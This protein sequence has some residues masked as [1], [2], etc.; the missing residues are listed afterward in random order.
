MRKPKVQIEN[1]FAS[2]AGLKS[3]IVTGLGFALYC[4]SGISHR[5]LSFCIYGFTLEPLDAYSLSHKEDFPKNK[6]IIRLFKNNLSLLQLK[7]LKLQFFRYH[8]FRLFNK[9]KYYYGIQA[10]MSV[11]CV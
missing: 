5:D 7:K 2:L 1:L 10:D 9:F 11:F 6:L 4:T 8:S 3:G